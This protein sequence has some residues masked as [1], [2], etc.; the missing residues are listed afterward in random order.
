MKRFAEIRAVTFDV[1]GTLIEAWPSVGHVYAE[2]AASH[3]I[4][5]LSPEEMSRRFVTAFRACK[6]SPN[7]AAEWAAVVD[8]VFAG[9]TAEPPS[10]TFFPKLYERFAQ[11]DAWRI[12]DDVVPTLKALAAR[13]I[14]LGVISNWDERLRP[15]LDGLKL[16]GRFETIVVSCEVGD[17]KPSPAIFQT[18]VKQ[19]ALPANAILHVGDNA[20]EDF[21]GAQAAGFQALLLSRKTEPVADSRI[22]RLTELPSFLARG[23]SSSGS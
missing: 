17:G 18:A 9:L 14:R 10:R 2:V 22:R 8:D 20:E 12:Y 21:A 6:P 16:A 4:K 3:G 15:L 1:G 19:L 11:A 5:N 23:R 7:G 13:G